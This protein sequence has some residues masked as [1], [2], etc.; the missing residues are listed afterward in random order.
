MA[1][2]VYICNPLSHFGELPEDIS[3]FKGSELDKHCGQG[4]WD[5]VDLTQSTFP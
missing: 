2:I 5:A 1:E 3:K 4:L